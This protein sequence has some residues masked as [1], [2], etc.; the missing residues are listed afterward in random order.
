[1]RHA[2]KGRSTI[3]WNWLLPLGLTTTE[4]H[5][6]KRFSPLALQNPQAP[7]APVW[8]FP[9]NVGVTTLDG[10]VSALRPLA[11]KPWGGNQNP[12]ATRWR[13]AATIPAGLTA[14][15]APAPSFNE[16]HP[17]VSR[18][19]WALTFRQRAR[20]GWSRDIVCYPPECAP[21]A[22]C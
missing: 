6:I 16:L 10:W 22:S 5:F 21:S 3:G 13:Y 1:V 17:L 12:L 20:I 18:R 7:A 11:L 8:L 2:L 15:P 9:T 19:H 14:G 4:R